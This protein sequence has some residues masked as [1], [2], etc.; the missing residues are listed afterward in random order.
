MSLEYPESIY[1][2]IY[3]AVQ[4]GNTLIRLGFEDLRPYLKRRHRRRIR[5][6]GR[7]AWRLLKP[8]GP[9]IDNRPSIVTQRT[10]IGDWEGDL[11][12][13]RKSTAALQSM[14]ERKTGLVLLTRMNRAT[15]A[16]MRTAACRSLRPFPSKFRQTLTLDNGSENTCWRDLEKDLD[17]ACFFAHPYHSW[18]RGTNENTN[19]LVRWYLPKGTDFSQVPECIIQAVQNALNNRPRKRLG[20]RTPVEVFN[21]SVALAS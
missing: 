15:A 12:V 1:Q 4:S 3:V 13:S 9:S 2:Y 6:G 16:E 18:E 14:V 19:G 20:W 7:S 10:R 17:L 11:I 8:H 21:E 5:K